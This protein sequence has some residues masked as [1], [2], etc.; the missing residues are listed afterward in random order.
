L[1]KRGAVL[2]D[3]FPGLEGEVEPRELGV[4]LFQE[5]H[6]PQGLEVVLEAAVSAHGG[7]EGVLARMAEGGVAEIMGQGDGFREG[8]VE[9]QHPGHAT[10]D[11]GHFQGVGEASAVEVALV[12][13]E[14]LSLVHEPPE[15]GGMDDAVP[16]PVVFGAV[17]RRSFR[18]FSAARGFGVSGEYGQ[19]CGAAHSD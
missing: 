1:M 11:L 15:G 7:I 17:C 6:H 5:V 12:I 14:H 16:V 3:A 2:E 8:F 9:I 4:A 13:D 10:G 18:I 19:R